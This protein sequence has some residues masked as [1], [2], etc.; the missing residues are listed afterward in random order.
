MYSAGLLLWIIRCV[1][2]LYCTPLLCNTPVVNCN[3]FIF[4]TRSPGP[5][6]VVSKCVELAN[7][8]AEIVCCAQQPAPVPAKH[9][10]I[11]EHYSGMRQKLPQFINMLLC[12]RVRLRRQE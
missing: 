4:A 9:F 8:P 7:K 1:A 2:L 3:Y 12:E 10:T 5:Y 6:V 11:C